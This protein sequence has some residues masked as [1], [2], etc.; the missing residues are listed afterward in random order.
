MKTNYFDSKMLAKLGIFS[1]LTFVL[2]ILEFPL[3]F[4]FPNFLKFNFS[5]LSA[6]ICGF[7]LGPV[8]GVIC[9]FVKVLLKYCFGLSYSGGVGELGDFIIGSFFV[10]VPA[11][12]YKKNK[13]M[14]SAV[15]GI[16]SGA[17]ASTAAAILMNIFVLIPFYSQL[18]GGMDMIISWCKPFV[19]AITEQ[20]FFSYYIPYLI[21]PFNILRCTVIGLITFFSYKRISNLLKKF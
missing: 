2:Y 19:P 18:L 1:A 10:V 13:S 9:E 8:A 14:G 17:L 7:T 21:L 15:T 20:N 16:V 3:P 11:L 5:D 4:L 12:M 6:L